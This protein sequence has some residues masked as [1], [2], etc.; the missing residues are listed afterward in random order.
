MH[1]NT[2]DVALP[3]HLRPVVQAKILRAHS[4]IKALRSQVH[5]VRAVLHGSAQGLHGTGRRKQFDHMDS[6]QKADSR[7]IKSY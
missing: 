4:R 1:L 7:N 5:R 2:P 6:L 3:H